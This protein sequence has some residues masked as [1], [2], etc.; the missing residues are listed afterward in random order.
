ME[1]N[2][3]AALKDLLPLA[4]NYLASDVFQRV[5]SA[6]KLTSDQPSANPLGDVGL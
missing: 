1:I 2:H 5:E 3:D 6:R 4:Q